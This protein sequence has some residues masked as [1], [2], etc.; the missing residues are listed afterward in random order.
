MGF[1]PSTTRLP[2]NLQGILCQPPVCPVC[3]PYASCV[4]CRAESLIITEEP[5]Y[6]RD[7]GTRAG[8]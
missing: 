3:L 4:C 1:P 2:W 7:G 5:G 6:G 8:C